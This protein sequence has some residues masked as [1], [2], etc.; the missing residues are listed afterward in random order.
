MW[1]EVGCVGQ[2]EPK[3]ASRKEH[4]TRPHDGP[5]VH[6]RQANRR[7]FAELPGPPELQGVADDQGA[8][9]V[10][11]VCFDSGSIMRRNQATRSSSYA[12]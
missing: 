3:Q 10:R 12:M 4:L 5:G 2:V 6:D 7:R 11:A 8:Y 9:G 1:D